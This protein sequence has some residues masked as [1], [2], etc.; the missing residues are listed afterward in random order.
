MPALDEKQIQEKLYGQY[1][2]GTLPPAEKSNPVELLPHLESSIKK[3]RVSFFKWVKPL[4]VQTVQLIARVWK[5]IPW[6]AISILA[7]ALI[8]SAILFQTI[9]LLVTKVK[10]VSFAAKHQAA[11]SAPLPQTTPAPPLVKQS[12][13]VSPATAGPSGPIA[14]ENQLAKQKAYAVQVCTYER[15]EDAR[16][17]VG[18]LARLNFSPF[19]RRTASTLDKARYEVFLGREKTYANAKA[20]LNQFRRTEPF[21]NFSDAFI[22]SI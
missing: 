18:R 19:Y 11:L 9:L 5:M 2:K 13:N 17:L 3:E 4:L 22:R 6:R 1:R 12:P 10:A 16:Q 7:G 20:L 14:S 21:R 8:I 15:E